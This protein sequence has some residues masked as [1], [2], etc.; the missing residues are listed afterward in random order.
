MSMDKRELRRLIGEKKRALTGREIE[1]RS[2]ALAEKLFA[3]SLYQDARSIY[4]YLSFNQEVLTRPVI[5][6][7]WADGKRVAVPKVIGR[8]MAFIWLDSFDHLTESGYGI[9]EPIEDSP[10]ADD[11]GALVLMPGLAFDP[12]GHRVGYGGG[13]YDRFLAREPGHPRAALCFDFQMFPHLDVEAH[14]VPAGLVI[15]DGLT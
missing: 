9:P 1:L 10:I 8:E 3:T 11:P 13:F 14:D 6:R 2:R 7:A 12:E 5:E 4:A 15:S